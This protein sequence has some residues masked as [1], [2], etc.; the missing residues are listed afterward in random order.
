MTLSFDV[1]S[2]DFYQENYLAK[3]HLNIDNEIIGMA[4]YHHEKDEEGKRKK[5]LD[6]LIDDEEYPCH[7]PLA[8]RTFI[9]NN[10]RT[11]YDIDLGFR[12]DAY[13]IHVD[14]NGPLEVTPTQILKYEEERFLLCKYKE[15]DLIVHLNDEEVDMNSNL[16]VR[17]DIDEMQ[18]FDKEKNIRLV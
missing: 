10:D 16:K 2:F 18:V 8:Y 5:V 3:P 4:Y 12:F 15:T 9:T 17:I 14:E 6:Y 11:L 1:K 13:Q 7:N